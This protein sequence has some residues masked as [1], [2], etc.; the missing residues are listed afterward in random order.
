MFFKYCYCKYCCCRSLQ[1]PPDILLLI[2]Q[3]KKEYM[4]DR[5]NDWH[6]WLIISF[7]INVLSK[8]QQYTYINKFFG[9]LFN[10]YDRFVRVSHMDFIHNTNSW[11]SIFRWENRSRLQFV[12]KN[13]F[14]NQWND[15][16]ELNNMWLK[17]WFYWWGEDRLV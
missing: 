9:K 3:S 5:V 14:I 8:L 17:T 10:S 2:Y 16:R 12:S 13:Y 6:V 15:E 1:L 7:A 11:L 4:N